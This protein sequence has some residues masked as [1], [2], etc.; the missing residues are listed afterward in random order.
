MIE[1]K[2]VCPGANLSIGNIEKIVDKKYGGIGI[3]QMKCVILFR[4][5]LFYFSSGH[6]AASRFGF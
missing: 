2:K 5:G 6:F 3:I 4:A 1:K